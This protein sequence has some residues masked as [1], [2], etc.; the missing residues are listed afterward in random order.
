MERKHSEQR[1]AGEE[2]RLGNPAHLIRQARKSI[3][4]EDDAARAIGGNRHR[5]WSAPINGECINVSS[6]SATSSCAGGCLQA[7]AFKTKAKSAIRTLPSAV[8]LKIGDLPQGWKVAEASKEAPAAGWI[9]IEPRG[10]VLAE[11]LVPASPLRRGEPLQPEAAHKPSRRASMTSSFEIAATEAS[12]HEAASSRSARRTEVSTP[13]ANLAKEPWRYGPC[14]R[15]EVSSETFAPRTARRT[16]IHGAKSLS[17]SA[18]MKAPVAQSPRLVPSSPSRGTGAT[19]PSRAPRNKTHSGLGHSP[20]R[21]SKTEVLLSLKE[22]HVLLRESNVDLREQ[23]L[24]RRRELE[25][26]ARARESIAGEVRELEQ[27]RRQLQEQH[28]LEQQELERQQ[29]VIKEKLAR[30]RDAVAFAVGSVDELYAQ[31]EAAPTRMSI[32]SCGQ[33]HSS[34]NTSIIPE[35]VCTAKALA[36]E[37]GIVVGEMLE[38]WDEAD[39]ENTVTSHIVNKKSGEAACPERTPLRTCNAFVSP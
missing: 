20:I 34:L 24:E 25:E 30:C 9:A 16:E 6:D 39:Q 31:Q 38:R 14:R 15:T 4:G 8:S 35:E 5:R 11:E 32:S 3:A 10:Y 37:A 17:R 7:K 36:V 12:S 18:S 26:L 2:R 1:A 19:S 29:T 13:S 27:S 33:G 28:D 23:E 22:E 21:Q